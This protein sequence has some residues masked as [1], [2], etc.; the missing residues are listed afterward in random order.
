LEV[1][2][3]TIVA[4]LFIGDDH[5]TSVDFPALQ[6]RLTPA[7]GSVEDVA[8]SGRYRNSVSTLSC[9]RRLKTE[10]VVATDEK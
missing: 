7:V 1:G 4:H 3:L 5:P 6:C 10:Q 9:R 2:L 8:A